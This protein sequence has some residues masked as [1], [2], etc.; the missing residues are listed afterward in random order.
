MFNM[1][2]RRKLTKEKD[3]VR[4]LVPMGADAHLDVEYARYLE[5]IGLETDPA[6]RNAL[7]ASPDIRFR[8]L[9]RYLAR[10]SAGKHPLVYWVKQATIDMAEMMAWVGKGQNARAFA[11]AQAAAP[12][13]NEA[14]AKDAESRMVGCTRCDGLGWVQADEGLPGD[15]PGY[16]VLRFVTRKTK[17]PELGEVT[18]EIPVWI[19]DCP[20]GCDRGKLREPGD[21]FSREKLLEQTGAINRRGPGIQITQHF[22]GQSM[23]SAVTRL[24][25]MTIDIDPG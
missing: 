20:M 14:M 19:R 3:E 1:K 17:D 5:E 12:K 6:L 8:E 7:A 10:P 16:R 25:P 4:G 22:G 9:L 13:I 18:E 15:T 21:E 11:L 2:P 23:P 24:E